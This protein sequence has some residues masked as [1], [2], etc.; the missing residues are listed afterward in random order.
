[1][2]VHGA[3]GLEAPIVILPDTTSDPEKRRRNPLLML[4]GAGPDQHVPLWAAPGLFRSQAFQGLLGDELAAAIAEH[5]RQLYVAMTRARDE[6][7]V[8]GHAG[9]RALSSLC[10][11]ET[12]RAG[13]DAVPLRALNPAA[14]P[15]IA[16]DPAPVPVPLPEWIERPVPAAAPSGGGTGRPP[17]RSG[18]RVA[19]GI[20]I[21][22]ILQ[23]LPEI[24]EK[25][26]TA[27]I[28]AA[29]ARSGHDPALALEL[30]HL[31]QH[32][33]FAEVFRADGLSE[34]AL[35]TEVPGRGPERRRI[36]RLVMNDRGILVVDYK[37]D[38]DWPN[39]ADGVSPEYLV[40]LA[41]YR[42]ALRRIHPGLPLRLALLWTE[43]P[44]LMEIADDILDH[45][46]G[47]PS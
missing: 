25:D 3:K 12:V 42:A 47:Q 33:D 32:P 7:Y 18:Q 22:R 15:A 14:P 36:D 27:H 24:E 1:M 28:Q 9:E 38:R 26:R 39:S 6:L 31:L 19:R 34:V 37:S 46:A 41:A 11:Y 10:W 20:L 40:Q 30:D 2:T 45:A 21:H 29:V 17:A 23:Q 13:L 8:C 16:A 35:I 44:R 5:Q 43:A 4:P